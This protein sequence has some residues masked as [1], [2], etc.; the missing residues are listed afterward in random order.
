MSYFKD[1]Y[2]VITGAASG[3]GLGISERFLERG[4][5]AVYMADRNEELLRYEAAELAARYPGQVFTRQTDVADQSQVQALIDCAVSEWGRIDFLFNNA[6]LPMTRPTERTTS[7]EFEKL[8]Q[9]NLLGPAYGTLAVLD[10][11]RRQG[12]GHIVNTASLGGLLPIPF[13]TA[14]CAT[15]AAVIAMTRCMAYEYAESGI[16]FSQLSPGNVATPIFAAEQIERMRKE[17]KSEAEIRQKVKSVKPPEGAMPLDAALDIL[18]RGLEE[19][20][21]DILCG[22]IAEEGYRL[23]CTDRAAYDELVLQMVER[24]RA[25]YKEL[26]RAMECGD[27]LPTF[28]G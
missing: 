25:F 4:G 11:M 13:Q 5:K 23:F 22:L 14:Y 3:L 2:A 19:K 21:T 27:P 10:I 15:K 24:R 18:F 1:K 12:S 16:Y 17:G 9:V 26:Y 28:P 6:G 8:V 20:K 7:E